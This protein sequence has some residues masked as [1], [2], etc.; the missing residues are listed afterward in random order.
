MMG[1][2]ADLPVLSPHRVNNSGLEFEDAGEA[3]VRGQ[4]INLR[5]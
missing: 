1:T 5:S 4:R 3:F 2:T